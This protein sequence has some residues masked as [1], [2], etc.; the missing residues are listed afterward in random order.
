MLVYAGEQEVPAGD[1]L[2]AMPLA[3]AVGQLRNL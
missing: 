1:G 3:T 2:R